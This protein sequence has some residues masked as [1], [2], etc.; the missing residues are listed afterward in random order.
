[1]RTGEILDISQGKQIVLA[2]TPSE[3]SNEVSDVL[4]SA[5]VSSIYNLRP[6]DS[7][8]ETIVG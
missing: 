7:E 6:T 5:V 1:M 2:V 4:N 8:D 3:Y